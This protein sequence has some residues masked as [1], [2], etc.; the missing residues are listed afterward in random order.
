MADHVCPDCDKTFKNI[1]GFLGHRA[2]VHGDHSATHS[3]VKQA[4]MKCLRLR[5]LPDETA[6]QLYGVLESEVDRLQ[7][8]PREQWS[9]EL[10]RVEEA[11]AR[12]P[13]QPVNRADQGTDEDGIP[14]WA[15][16]GGAAFLVWILTRQ[17]R[18]G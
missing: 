9:G 18:G 17:P 2:I 6:T 7:A 1:Q 12:I 15:V 16:L 8:L 4:V 5:G 13:E 3:K 10:S 11:L 14:G